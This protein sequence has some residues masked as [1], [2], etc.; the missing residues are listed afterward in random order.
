MSMTGPYINDPGFEVPDNKI[1]V[2]PF[3][4]NG[5]GGHT[6]IIESL[7]GK[8]KR[9]WFNP[10]FYYC[11]PLNIGN[12]QGF[13]IKSL[14]DFDMVWDGSSKNPFDVAFTFKQDLKRDKQVI[15]NG[16]GE[17]VVTVQNM[18]SLKTPPGVNL[19]TIQPPNMFIPGCVALTGIIETDQIRRDFT[20]NFKITIPNYTISVK[21]G[22]ALGAFIPVP[23]YYGDNFTLD[24]I[25][26]FF[27]I[28]L[29]QNELNDQK[30][31]GR[32]RLSED[33][34]KAHESGRKYFNGI[35][36]F[37]EKYRDHQRGV[38]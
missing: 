26:N 36:A 33:K 32:Q 4:I 30:E 13:I 31:L 34:N 8:I 23:R 11:L 9:D 35:H 25:S 28:K 12:Q 14:I 3:D 29:H 6:E 18:F 15:Q 2:I 37:G 22:D 20:F 38:I 21:R 10:H 5:D 24:S 16:F 27:D 17:G 7:K 1:L 19:M